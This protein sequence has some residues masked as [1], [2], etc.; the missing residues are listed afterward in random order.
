MRTYIAAFVTAAL[1]FSI[2]CASALLIPATAPLIVA[3]IAFVSF[4]WRTAWHARSIMRAIWQKQPIWVTIAVFAFLF[5]LALQ[6]F[7]Y[8]KHFSHP[9]SY[10][11]L[12]AASTLG[13]VAALSAALWHQAVSW[14]GLALWTAS[15]LLL[16][17]KR[18]LKKTRPGF[19][20]PGLS[21]LNP[22]APTAGSWK[23]AAKAGID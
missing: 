22:P 5:F 10:I 6:V 3:D 19:C 16:L 21:L 4:V 17:L 8:F 12:L 15:K 11:Q 14:L 23:Q 13:G 9:F 20:S 1:G 18:A 2:T 7:I